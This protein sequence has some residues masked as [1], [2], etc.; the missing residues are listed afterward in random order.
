MSEENAGGDGQNGAILN[1]PVDVIIDK[2]L[3][4]DCLYSPPLLLFNKECPTEN[5]CVWSRSEKSLNFGVSAE[6]KS[7]PG[8]LL[9]SGTKRGEPR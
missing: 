9:N 5:R 2:L 6:K 7:R 3:R 4:Y 8:F 1:D